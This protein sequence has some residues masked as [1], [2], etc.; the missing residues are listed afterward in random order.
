[1]DAATTIAAIAVAATTI[2]ALGVPYIQGR[3][4]AKHALASKLRDERIAAYA[5]A[6]AYV[7]VVQTRV[8]HIVE[9]PAFRESSYK[10]PDLPQ[11]DLITARLELLAPDELIP[12]WNELTEAWEAFVWT[13]EEESPATLVSEASTDV[14]RVRT[15]SQA[16][17]A[18]LRR[19]AGVD[20]A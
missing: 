9:D 8:D 4:A 14:K 13:I 10:R 2:T 5:D 20:Q 17:T 1:M 15:A 16:L 19:A 7:Q 11:R 18:E 6:M 3:I 12:M